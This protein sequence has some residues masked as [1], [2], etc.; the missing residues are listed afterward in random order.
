MPKQGTDGPQSEAG[1]GDEETDLPDITAAS[2]HLPDMWYGPGV[3][4]G[5]TRQLT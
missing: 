3:F 5:D 4:F 2:M 1:R